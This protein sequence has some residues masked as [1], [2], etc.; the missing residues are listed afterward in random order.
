[1]AVER[2]NSEHRR[3]SIY[4]QLPVP[5]ATYSETATKTN[6]KAPSFYQVVES[7]AACVHSSFGNMKPMTLCA[8]VSQAS[9]I[10]QKAEHENTASS[11]RYSITFN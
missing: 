5:L 10:I 9:N 8:T 6:T 2:A 11:Q 4:L 7:I 1:M 3:L